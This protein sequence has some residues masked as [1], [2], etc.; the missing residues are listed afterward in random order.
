MFIFP[1][2]GLGAIFGKCSVVSDSM[3]MIAAETLASFITLE[4]LS[5]GKVYPDVD[6]IRKVSFKIAIAVIKQ[7][8]IEGVCAKDFTN[9]TDEDFTQYVRLYFM[10]I[11]I[12]Q[13][14]FFLTNY[15]LIVIIFIVGQR[16]L[17]TRIFILGFQRIWK[18]I[19][20]IKISLIYIIIFY[21]IY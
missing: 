13:I 9:W 21:N 2:L 19:I 1:G 14:Q 12:I 10:I 5:I 20:E 16:S 17:P 15:L 3:L 11:S 4:D 6:D 18:R 8:M 7:A